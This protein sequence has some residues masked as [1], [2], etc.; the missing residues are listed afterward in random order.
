MD[1]KMWSLLFSEQNKPT[2]FEEEGYDREHRVSNRGI[3]NT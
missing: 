3:E 2:I 1:V